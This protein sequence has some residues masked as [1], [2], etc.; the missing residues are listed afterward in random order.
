VRYYG[1]KRFCTVCGK[2]SRRFRHFGLVP[3][4]DAQCAHCGALERHRFLWL[5]LTKKTD[6]FDGR[7]KQVL[8]VAPEPCFV[9]RLKE[10]IG[11]GY[12]TADLEDPRVMVNMDV[13]NITYPDQSFDV[14]YCSHVLEHVPD[15][16]RALGEFHRVL[17]DNGW[18]ILL[19]PPITAEKTFEDPTIVDADARAIA[20]GQKDH[21]RRYGKDYIDRLRETGFEVEVTEVKD[22]VEENEAIKMG[23]THS[24]G[25]IYYCTK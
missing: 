2:S 13:T 1:N 10:R 23:L 18:A 21:V 6:L 3:R 22:F 15:D 19:V 5:Y 14:I 4:A 20:F 11:D 17:K 12:V 8:H 7:E 25:E 24:S 9:S 16:K